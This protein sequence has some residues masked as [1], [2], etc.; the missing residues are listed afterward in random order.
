MFEELVNHIKNQRSDAEDLK[1]KVSSAAKAAMQ[2]DAQAS[3]RLES[4]LA[5]ERE[6]AAVDRQELLSQITTLINK[7]AEAQD[8]R[9]ESKIHT[10][11]ADIATSRTNLQ[12]ADKEY[13]D[14][15]DAWSKKEASLVKEVLQSRDTLK[16]KMKNDWTVYAFE[17]R[18]ICLG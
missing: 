18:N 4:C 2:A 8:A 17:P 9:W 7:S 11:K 15:M 6:R 10:V 14:N 1:T 13:N 5:E 16:G 3:S 12:A